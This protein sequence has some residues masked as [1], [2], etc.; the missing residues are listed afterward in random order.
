MP[1]NKGANLKLRGTRVNSD[2]LRKFDG[3]VDKDRIDGTINGGGIP[4]NV[5]AG[6]GRVKLSFN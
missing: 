6:N 2:E 3:S 4:V 1:G 5:H